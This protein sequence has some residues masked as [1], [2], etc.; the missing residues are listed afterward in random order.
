MHQVIDRA[1][2]ALGRLE[3]HRR[4]V[5]RGMELGEVIGYYTGINFELL[6]LGTAAAAGAGDAEV[7]RGLMQYAALGEIKEAA[8]LERALL[9]NALAAGELGTAQRLALQDLSSR[10]QAH[11]QLFERLAGEQTLGLHRQLLV[12]PTEAVDRARDTALMGEFDGLGASHWWQIA[13]V[14][15][16]ALDEL[17]QQ[18]GAAL[19]AEVGDQISSAHGAFAVNLAAMLFAVPLIAFAWRV[20][21]RIGVRVNRLRMLMRRVRKELDLGLRAED[22]AADD[23][24]EMAA[25]LNEMLERFSWVVAE[26]KQS[27]LEL[28]SPAEQ[29][30]AVSE[31]TSQGIGRQQSQTEQVATAMNEM[32]ATVQEI[33]RLAQEAAQKAQEADT[34]TLATREGVQQML[35]A[36]EHLTGE[37]A[38][39]ADVVR[40][41]EEQSTR[42]GSV[43]AII[44]GITEQTNLLALNA[45]IEAARAG[46]AGRGFAVVADEVRTLAVRTRESTQEIRTVIE[47]LQTEAS[48]AAEA[49]AIS[50]R[51]CRQTAEL[52][53]GAG[54]RLENVVQAVAQIKDMNLQIAGATEEQS[55]VAAEIDHS[56]VA[57]RDIALETTSGADQTAA[58]SEQLAR[59]ARSLEESSR[60]FRVRSA[61]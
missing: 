39:A 40:Q 30:A 2:Q 52:A 28:A 34:E 43:V 29:L 19:V 38:R 42:I 13:S 51:D 47:H 1:E 41:L 37:I 6:R 61:A 25:A 53:A 56:V 48:G 9:A 21:N 58:S 46:G 45:S 57:I 24:G 27:A 12:A 33:A 18:L 49:M 54:E 16:D 14:R 60:V 7:M 55:A 31:Q 32:S 17:Q 20:S 11:E 36:M 10:Q 23:L 15:I 4:S 8:G 35:A 50:Q 5:N 22:E 3:A 59:L 26:V 44:D